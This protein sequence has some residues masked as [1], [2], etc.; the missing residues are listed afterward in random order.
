MKVRALDLV[1]RVPEPGRHCGRWSGLACEAFFFPRLS[2]SL[3]RDFKLVDRKE[4]EGFVVNRYQSDDKVAVSS[5]TL[6]DDAKVRRGFV[7]LPDD[8][9]RT[10]RPP[11]SR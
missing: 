6:L 4:F 9:L 1:Y 7:L 5:Q 8:R 3:A 2:T 10:Y 11:N